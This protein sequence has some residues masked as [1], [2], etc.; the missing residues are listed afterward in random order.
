MFGKPF[1]MIWQASSEHVNDDICRVVC[2]QFTVLQTQPCMVKKKTCN[3]QTC[4]IPWF[5]II[6]YI[7]IYYWQS[8]SQYYAMN[9]CPKIFIFD[10][11]THRILRVAMAPLLHWAAGVGAAISIKV[12]SS[13]EPR[14]AWG[15]SR[16]IPG[17]TETATIT[18]PTFTEKNG[19]ERV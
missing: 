8:L 16:G 9:E 17:G 10:L 4:I 13:I 11:S 2:F 19:M 15:T 3:M 7:Y 1:Q 18:R 6:L 12:S 5:P 14:T